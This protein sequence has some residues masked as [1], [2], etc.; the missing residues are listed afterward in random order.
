MRLKDY[1]RNRKKRKDYVQQP[2]LLMVGVDVDN[3]KHDASLGT[4]FAGQEA[5]LEAIM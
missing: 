5:F 3:V 4:Q 2:D 1:V